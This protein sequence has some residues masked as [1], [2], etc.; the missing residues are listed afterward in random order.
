MRR[1]KEMAYF[2]NVSSV[3]VTIPGKTDSEK[4]VIGS[5]ETVHMPDEMANSKRVQN[6]KRRKVLREVPRMM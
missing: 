2:R 1:L 6:L 5:R 3:T 4:Y